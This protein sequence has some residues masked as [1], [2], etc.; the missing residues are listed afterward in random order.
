L[1]DYGFFER[2]NVTVDGRT[3]VFYRR[4]PG[5]SVKKQI[6][7]NSSGCPKIGLQ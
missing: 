7:T 3:I 1:I 5:S 4:I 2:N 6:I